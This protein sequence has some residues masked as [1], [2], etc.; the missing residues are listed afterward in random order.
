MAA[1]V[2][3]GQIRMQPMSHSSHAAT[4]QAA[5]PNPEGTDCKSVTEQVP[6]LAL[7]RAH[8]GCRQR[9]A[10]SL[11]IS[12]RGRSGHIQAAGGQQ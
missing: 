4:G 2:R 6:M 11:W 8:G 1:G 9:H 12:A 7:R 3:Y 5:A 10:S